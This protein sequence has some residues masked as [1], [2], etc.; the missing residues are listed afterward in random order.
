MVFLGKSQLCDMV[1]SHV[2]KRY[3]ERLSE[4][5]GVTFLAFGP[6][7]DQ[8][9]VVNVSVFEQRFR[10]VEKAPKCF[11][12]DGFHDDENGTSNPFESLGKMNNF[13]VKMTKK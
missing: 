1:K 7:N 4:P 9:V 11:P 10:H 13:W 6:K 12:C 2:E 3:R 8:K 5:F